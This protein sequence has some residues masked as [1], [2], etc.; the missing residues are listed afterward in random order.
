MCCC[1]WIVGMMA[2]VVTSL[3]AQAADPYFCVKIKGVDKEISMEVMPAA[4]FKTLENA[5]KLEQKYFP[6]IIEKI[7]MNK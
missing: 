2:V 5:I 6:K 3:A 1:K 7:I 4:D